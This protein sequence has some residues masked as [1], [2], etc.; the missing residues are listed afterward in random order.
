MKTNTNR[1]ISFNNEGDTNFNLLCQYTLSACGLTTF[2]DRTF[3]DTGDRWLGLAIAW[4]KLL[5]GGSVGIF[6]DAVHRIMWGIPPKK[7]KP[8]YDG[9]VQVVVDELLKDG[10]AF[11]AWDSYNPF[12]VTI[13]LVGDEMRPWVDNGEDYSWSIEHYQYAEAKMLWKIRYSKEKYKDDHAGRQNDYLAYESAIKKI[14]PNTASWPEEYWL[15]EDHIHNELI[16]LYGV[17]YRD[18]FVEYGRLL[19]LLTNDEASPEK[20]AINEAWFA[21]TIKRMP[22]ALAEVIWPEDTEQKIMEI[23]LLAS[24]WTEALFKSGI[25][26]TARK[27]REIHPV[28]IFEY[29]DL[30]ESWLYQLMT[31]WFQD[32]DNSN[33]FVHDVKKRL[34]TIGLRS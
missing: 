8:K 10:A 23:F 6:E 27:E 15:K 4:E 31:E 29:S 19:Q 28:G 9:I 14:V 16:S 17:D 3:S 20:Y 1:C 32:E 34:F 30:R 26:Y 21:S 13:E 5:D 2:P 33:D 22:M 7:S 11:R 25:D 24:E 12:E 18:D